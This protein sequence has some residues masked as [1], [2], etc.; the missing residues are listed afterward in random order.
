M[1]TWL[2]LLPPLIAIV[3]AIRTRQ[4]LLSLLTGIFSGSL[5]LHHFSIY[6]AFVGTVEIVVKVIADPDNARML[7]FSLMIGSVVLL[8]QRSGGVDGF[9]AIVSRPRLVDSPRKAGL[10]ATLIGAGLF[11]EGS[12]SILTVGTVAKPLFRK[13]RLSREKLAYIADSTAAPAKVLIPLNGWGAFL[14][15]HMKQAGVGHPFVLL[16]DSMPFFFY[17]MSAFLLTLAAIHVP[18]NLGPMKEAE[19]KAKE[20]TEPEEPAPGKVQRKK[21]EALYFLI[22]ILTLVGSLFTFMNVTGNG[23]ITAGDGSKSILYSI[24]VTLAV[25]YVLYRSRNVFNTETF[26]RICLEG[27][28]HLLEVVMIL[29][30]AFAINAVCREL[31]T[32]IY[33]AGILSAHLPQ[34]VVPALIFLISALISFATGTSW[35]TFAIML[36][37]GVPMA[38]SLGLPLPVIAGAVVSGGVWGDHCSPISD[39]TVLAALASGCP[40]MDHVKTQMP[41]ALLGGLISVVLFLFIGFLL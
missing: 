12:M 13:F 31:K 30:L 34:A 11:L 23:N 39:T 15:M 38:V 22:P 10:L 14:M 20:R 17:P 21:R 37:I 33:A 24:F 27:M 40:L 4:V 36:S 28:N 41:Y 19:K 8:V 6:P 9:V 35:G 7:L 25:S 26:I 1:N 5:I 29:A 16:M 3:L 32:G 18:W 2:S